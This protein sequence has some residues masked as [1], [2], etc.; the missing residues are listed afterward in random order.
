MPERWPAIMRKTTAAEYLDVS[1]SQ[2]EKLNLPCVRW[3][4]RGDR[5]YVREDLD[6]AIERLRSQPFKVEDGGKKA[7]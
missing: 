5:M 2:F 1:I 7:A 4:E 3:N 6:A